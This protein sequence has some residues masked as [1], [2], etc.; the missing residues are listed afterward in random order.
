MVASTGGD[1]VKLSEAMASITD[2]S[3]ANRYVVEVYGKIVDDTGIV[4]KSY[5]DVVGFNAD[6]TVAN[7]SQVVPGYAPNALYFVDVT[8]TNWRNLTVRSTGEGNTIT[9]GMYGDI[10]SSV[11]FGNMRFINEATGCCNKGAYI[12]D[13]VAAVF[14]DSY[15]KGSDNNDVGWNDGAVTSGQASPTF[16]SCIFEAGNGGGTGSTG[17]VSIIES[18][19]ILNNG[20]YR[21]GTHPEG[22]W[23]QGLRAEDQSAPIVNGG[24]A[25]GGHGEPSV[26]FNVVFNAAPVVNGLTVHNG[27]GISARGLFIAQTS[28]PVINNVLVTPQQHPKIWTYTSEEEGRFRPF[29][30]YPYM[31]IS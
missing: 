10:D 20:I 18:T 28:S 26:G 21:G 19:P 31:I 7:P 6:V 17:F 22:Q 12:R 23:Q 16:N 9:L 25:F 30:D 29:D 8:E 5:V 27:P 4:G 3:D 14:N 1:Y 24:V 15:F 11:R 2:A 13:T